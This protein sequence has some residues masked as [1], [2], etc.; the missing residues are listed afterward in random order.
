MTIMDYR[1]QLADGKTLVGAKSATFTDFTVDLGAADPNVGRGEPIYVHVK[2]GTAV[3]SASAAA[4]TLALV[5]QHS[6]SNSAASMVNLMNLNLAGASSMTQ[7][8]LTA[9]KL[10]Y[11]GAL[12]PVCRRYVRLKGTIGVTP[13]TAG[14]LDAWLDIGPLPTDME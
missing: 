12:P 5:L 4:G 8:L 3:T 2:I 14:T 6:H 7:N 13:I 10:I 1:C 9:N 11:S